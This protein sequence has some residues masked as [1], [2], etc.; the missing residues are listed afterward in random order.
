MRE[1]VSR[2]GYSGVSAQHN[3]SGWGPGLNKEEKASWP[4]AFVYPC[5]L[6]RWRVIRHVQFPLLCLSDIGRLHLCKPHLKRSSLFLR[7]LL[8]RYLVTAEQSNK[9]IYKTGGDYP[10]LWG[11]LQLGKKIQNTG[12][13]STIVPHQR[14][15]SF[16]RPRLIHSSFSVCL[17]YCELS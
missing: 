9:H 17:W 15:A 13:G 3:Y 14:G 8:V 16:Q 7:G 4:L 10:W 6:T 11:C 5:F 2:L 1:G 12:D